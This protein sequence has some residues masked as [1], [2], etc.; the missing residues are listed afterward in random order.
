MTTAFTFSQAVPRRRTARWPIALAG[1]L[2]A[3]AAPVVACEKSLPR[4]IAGTESPPQSVAT[5]TGEFVNGAPVYR[6]PPIM[7]VSRRDAEIARAQR[8]GAPAHAVR[9]PA[10]TAPGVTTP[11][12]KVAGASAGAVA[13][14]PCIG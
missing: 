6:L 3:V 10:S 2:I 5:F 13:V 14:T 11:K 7:V 8:S 9:S 1:M 4:S 12:R